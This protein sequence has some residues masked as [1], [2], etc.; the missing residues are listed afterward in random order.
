[1]QLHVANDLIGPLLFISFLVERKRG[2]VNCRQLTHG[3]VAMCQCVQE[4]GWSVR[5][6]HILWSRT[7]AVPTGQHQ[8]PNV[9]SVVNIVNLT[10]WAR[11]HGACNGSPRDACATI[12]CIVVELSTST[13]TRCCA[14]S[15]VCCLLFGACLLLAIGGQC[16]HC[17]D[18]V[19]RCLVTPGRQLPLVFVTTCTVPRADW[20][21]LLAFLRP[22]VCI[23]TSLATSEPPLLIMDDADTKLYCVSRIECAESLS[24]CL[25]HRQPLARVTKTEVLLLLTAAAEQFNNTPGVQVDV[26]EGACS[27]R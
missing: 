1:M 3:Q 21:R 15:C 12:W 24:S 19:A 5:Q 17:H 26:S 23:H 8:Q 9:H 20:G 22:D 25:H 18:A 2:V 13:W 7:A 10:C 27:G 11:L 16:A 14:C 6:Q 4:A